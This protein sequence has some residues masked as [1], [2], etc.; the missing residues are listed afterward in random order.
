MEDGLT[1]KNHAESL[2]IPNFVSLKMI[3]TKEIKDKSFI[4]NKQIK[5]KRLLMENKM[6]EINRKIIKLLNHELEC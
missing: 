4:E 1:A 2:D 6:S 5:E 3:I